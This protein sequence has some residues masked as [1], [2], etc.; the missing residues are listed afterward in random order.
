MALVAAFV[1]EVLA[2]A[3]LVLELAAL[4]E[5]LVAEAADS[6]AFVLAVDAEF[7]AELALVV[8]EF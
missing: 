4:A 6:P 7:D 2:L 8:A 1:A 3:A 5:A